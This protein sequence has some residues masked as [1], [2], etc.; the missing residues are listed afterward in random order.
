MCQAASTAAQNITLPV[1]RLG[2]HSAENLIQPT[3]GCLINVKLELHAYF[4]VPFNFDWSSTPV[5]SPLCSVSV[6]IYHTCPVMDHLA[7]GVFHETSSRLPK[8]SHLR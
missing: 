4:R 1:R 2:H 3:V 6:L 5:Q 7:E 8:V